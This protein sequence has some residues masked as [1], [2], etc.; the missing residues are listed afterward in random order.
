MAF[1]KTK[2]PFEREEIYISH[3]FIHLSV[4]EHLGC[5]FHFLAIP[6]NAAANIGVH[7]SFQ[8]SVIFFFEYPELDLVDHMAALVLIFF[9]EYPYHY[10]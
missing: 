9:E 4:N 10:T 3:I 8:I 1:P 5:F 6:S 7:V 2:I